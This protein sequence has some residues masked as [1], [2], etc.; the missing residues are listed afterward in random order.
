MISVILNKLISLKSL[1]GLAAGAAATTIGSAILGKVGGGHH[2][3][4]GGMMGGMVPGVM[5][6]VLGGGHNK[7]KH[8]SPIPIGGLAAGAG[9]AALGAAMLTGHHPVSNWTG[10]RRATCY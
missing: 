7:S 1:G 10:W 9:A 2:K 5:G 6:S 8:S 3:H 4:G